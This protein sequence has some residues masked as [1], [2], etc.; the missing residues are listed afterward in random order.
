MS[1]VAILLEQHWNAVPGGTA[2][3][4]VGLIDALGEIDD[5]SVI[6]VH[7][8]HRGAPTMPINSGLESVQVPFSGRLMTESWSRLGQP[9]IDRWLDAD[10]LHAPAY[11]MPSTELA[12]VVT[13][14][15]LAFVRHPEWFTSNGVGFFNRF[16]ERVRRESC[17]VIVPS[18][19][20][21]ADCVD[22]GIDSSR[23]HVV[24]WGIDPV[25]V[26]S[27][28]RDRVRSEH[29]LPESFALFV[30]TV[31][32]RKNLAGLLEAMELVGDLPLVIVGPDGWGDIPTKLTS[33]AHLRLS[34]LSRSDLDAVMSTADVLVY[35]S[36][37]EGFGLPVLEAMAV[38]TPVVTTAGTAAAELMGSGGLAVDTSSPA[39][40]AEV[41]SQVT[42]DSNLASTL[43]QEGLERAKAYPWSAA[44]TKTVAI[45]DAAI[46]K[47]AGG[48]SG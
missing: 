12:A 45:Y 4:I 31:E 6:G 20:T 5:V 13:I 23:I 11:V 25:T 42:N 26:T 15:D 14:H 3:S 35:P 29:G 48:K 30:G 39:L 19:T 22:A 43:G 10:V 1:R 47:A 7:G 2:S 24:P 8:R 32:P 18:N 9:S 41:I 34:G 44:A 21:A 17:E 28:D 46:T 27:S 37:F 36:H 40:L 33:S 38:G 16:L